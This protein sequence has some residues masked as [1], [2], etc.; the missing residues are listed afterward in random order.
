MIVSMIE[1]L[2]RLS[3]E[4]KEGEGERER[5]RERERVRVRP[6]VRERPGLLCYTCRNWLETHSELTCVCLDAISNL[7]IQPELDEQV[8]CMCMNVH[9]SYTCTYIHTYIHAVCTVDA[10]L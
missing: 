3:R 2:P 10:R 9:Y 6:R 8:H 7:N 4:R 1:W 5:E